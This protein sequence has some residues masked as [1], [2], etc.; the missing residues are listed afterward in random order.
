MEGIRALWN[1]IR[2][3]GQGFPKPKA[4]TGM[5]RNTKAARQPL[6]KRMQAWASS[7]AVPGMAVG[8]GTATETHF[9]GAAGCADLESQRPVDAAK[10]VFRIASVSKPITATAL[11]RMVGAGTLGLEDPLHAYVPEFPHPG[12]TI[13]QLASHTAG[14]RGYRGKEM[15]LNR[16]MGIAGALP[17][18]RDDPLLSPPGTAYHY[19]SFDFVLLSLAM[20]RAAGKP[21]HTLVEEEVLG[22]LGML[23]TTMEIPGRPREGQARFYSRGRKG[24]RPAAP[25][26]N[27]YKLAGGGYLSTVPDILRLGQAYLRGEVA[28]AACLEEF[29]S[30]VQIGG[31]PTWYGLGWEVSRDA[32]GEPYY[33]HTGH[34]IG[35]Y[36]IFRIYPEAG[37]VVV[38]LINGPDP[39]SRADTESFLQDLKLRIR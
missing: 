14:L 15:A 22:P 39:G 13:R 1:R 27:R 26:D 23:Q 35:A 31:E 37:R 11:A 38:L 24:F 2:S 34:S 5:H 3:L 36:S 17:I 4:Q 30:S 20:Q 18:F 8:A 10:T 32:S 19:S 33:G 7:S 25:V 28:P 16:P 12:I 9:L 6:E 29:L 21:F